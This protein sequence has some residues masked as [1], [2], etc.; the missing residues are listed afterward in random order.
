MLKAI[1]VRLYPSSEQRQQL[2]FQ[3][4]AMRWVYNSAFELALNGLERG[5]R[6][7]R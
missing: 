5:R 2:A 1:K 7:H 4:G 6:K 3:F